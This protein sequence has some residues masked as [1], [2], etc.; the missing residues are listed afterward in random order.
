[1][2]CAQATQPLDVS[3]LSA[4]QKATA[5]HMSALGI[6]K[7]AE[8]RG[9]L[10]LCPTFLA[11]L[12][13]G[14]ASAPTTANASIAGFIVVETSFR[15]YAYT[16][17][18]VQVRAPSHVRTYSGAGQ[19][20]SPMA[21]PAFVHVHERPTLAGRAWPRP[22][23]H[24]RAV[25]CAAAPKRRRL[26][27]DTC[28]AEAC[29]CGCGKQMEVCVQIAILQLFAK[30]D[31]LLPNVFVGTLTGKS[32]TEALNRKI[33]SGMIIRYLEDHRHPKVAHRSPVLPEAVKDQIILWEKELNR[34]SCTPAALITGFDTEGIYDA[35]VKKA[36]ELGGLLHCD[37]TT[38]RLVVAGTVA[39]DLQ[40]HIEMLRK[41]SQKR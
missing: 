31:C 8:S 6:L 40:R 14:T 11:G 9:Q 33:S 21:T 4:D 28:P 26:H 15:L 2:T 20:L 1:M 39:D 24:M 13:C 7:P 17:S 30:T 16:S 3:Q 34:L 27:A 22:S 37:P 25:K 41:R 5:S 18:P 35:A 29:P 10:F 38:Q 23:V 36:E 12:L 19:H 32:V